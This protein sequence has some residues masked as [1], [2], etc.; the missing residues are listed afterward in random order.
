MRVGRTSCAL[1]DISSSLQLHTVTKLQIQHVSATDSFHYYAAYCI[2][3]DR[4]AGH[5]LLSARQCVRTARSTLTCKVHNQAHLALELAQRGVLAI[6]VLWGQK[7]WFSVERVSIDR[8]AVA[9][10]QPGGH[11]ALQPCLLVWTAISRLSP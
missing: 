2:H 9:G 5:H 11:Q 7:E 6:D 8:V 4:W 1:K 10:L 3:P